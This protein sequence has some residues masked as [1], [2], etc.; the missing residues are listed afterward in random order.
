MK[1]QMAKSGPSAATYNI[2]ADGTQLSQLFMA[3][4]KKY[5]NESHLGKLT[6]MMMVFCEPLSHTEGTDTALAYQVSTMNQKIPCFVIEK[7]A[8]L[9]SSLIPY[10]Q[11]F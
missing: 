9:S 3:R 11:G 2:G 8:R 10:Y 1:M 4:L 7:T 5:F 6:A